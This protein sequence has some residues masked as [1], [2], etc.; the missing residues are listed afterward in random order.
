M[1]TKKEGVRTAMGELIAKMEAYR[2]YELDKHLSVSGLNFAINVARELLTKERERE[3]KIAS[4][5]WDA[6]VNNTRDLSSHPPAHPNKETYL[7]TTFK[8]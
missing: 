6:A 5:A 1:E 8:Q 7:T 2:D 4:D 3:M